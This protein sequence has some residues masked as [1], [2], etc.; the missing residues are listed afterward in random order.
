LLFWY[1]IKKSQTW[2]PN[3][4]LNCYLLCLDKHFSCIIFVLLEYATQF[5]LICQLVMWSLHTTIFTTLFTTWIDWTE[6]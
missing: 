2:F 3:L 5:V 1:V 4:N 6:I